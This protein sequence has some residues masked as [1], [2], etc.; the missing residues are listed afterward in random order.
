MNHFAKTVMIGLLLLGSP[1]S[2]LKTLAQ[3]KEGDKCTEKTEDKKKEDEKEVSDY[4][5][6]FKDKKRRRQRAHFL[7]STNSGTKCMQSF[8]SRTSTVRSCSG[9]P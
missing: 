8:R 3:E 6:L 2:A 5:K 1:S 4:D 9:L 7:R